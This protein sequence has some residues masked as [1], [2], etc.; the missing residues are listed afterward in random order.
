M[1]KSTR[2]ADIEAK[3]KHRQLR[4]KFS[5]V[6]CLLLACFFRLPSQGVAAMKRCKTDVEG[7]PDGS[8]SLLALISWSAFLLPVLLLP[9]TVCVSFPHC[10]SF[11]SLFP[12]VPAMCVY[13]CIS[14][15]AMSLLYLLYL[16]YLCYISAISLAAALAAAA[17]D[18]AA[19]VAALAAADSL[20]LLL[21]HYT[22][23]LPRCSC[24]AM[25]P[26]SSRDIA[27]SKVRTAGKMKGTPRLSQADLP[28]SS[29][30][31]RRTRSLYNPVSEIEAIEP[32]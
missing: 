28:P 2:A 21:L 9:V 3:I 24:V 5:P 6:R 23:F 26:F 13:L 29:S 19:A 15:P 1:S 10:V 11:S 16:L 22:V 27:R 17:L 32:L 8:R 7:V 18:A 20:L 25:S 4:T 30:V 14:S 12:S 31:S